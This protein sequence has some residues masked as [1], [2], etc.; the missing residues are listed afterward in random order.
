VTDRDR[1][2]QANN[3]NVWNDPTLAQQDQLQ[4]HGTP[5]GN[6][7]TAQQ[8]R[9]NRRPKLGMSFPIR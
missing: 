7:Q 1:Q 8:R 5:L 9:R 3:R 2:R 4:Q 6:M